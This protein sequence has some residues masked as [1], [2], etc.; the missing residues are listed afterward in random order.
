LWFGE[1]G[2]MVEVATAL[3]AGA[4]GTYAYTDLTGGATAYE[5]QVIAYN[6]SKASTTGPVWGFVTECN[7]EIPYFEGFEANHTN[8]TALSNCWSQEAV[9]GTNAWTANSSETNYNRT[10][11]TGSWNA[12]LRYSNTRWMFQRISVVEATSYTVEVYARQDGATAANASIA[13]SYGATPDA[14]AMTNEIVAQTGII[15]GN[16]Q[17]LTGTFTPA[18]S[19]DIYLGILGTINDTPWYISIDDISVFETPSCLPPSSLVSSNITT[20]TADLG[21]TENGTATTWNIL[22]G[23]EDFD[24]ETEGTSINGV[25]DNPYT[26]EGL[27]SNNTYDWYVQADCGAKEESDWVGP[28]T[29]TTLPGAHP[30][31]LAEDFESGFANFANAAG[32]DVAWVMN[33]DIFHG[34]LQS[35]HNA[36]GANNVNILHE[37]GILDLSGTSAATLEF[38][39]IAKTE[40]GYDKCYVEISIDGGVSYT[41]LPAES[42]LGAGT[43]YGSAGYF[44]EDDYA[45]W[46][47]GTEVP[48]NTWW[49][50]E[51]FSLAAYNTTNVRF[52]FRLTSDGSAQRAGWYIDDILIDEPACPAPTAL[53]S[54]NET[55]TGADLSWTDA[56]GSAWDLYIV[57]AGDPAP[58]GATVPTVD[59]HASTS[60]T[61]AGGVAS[62]NYE[63]YVRSDCGG[64]NTDVSDWSGPGSFSTLCEAVTDFSEDFDG[65]TAPAIPNCWQTI[66]EHPTSTFAHVQTTTGTTPHSAPNHVSMYNTFTASADIE[67]LLISPQVDSDLTERRLR[68]HAKRGGSAESV[69]VG[70]ITDPTDAATFTPLTTIE[71]TA[72]YTEYIYNLDGYAGADEYIAFRHAN[73][74]TTRFV[75]LDNINLEEIPTATLSWYN[76]QWPE[77][78]AIPK[79]ENVTIFAQ[80]WESGVTEPDGPGAGIEAWIGYSDT[81]ATELADFA[82]GWT[83]IAAEYNF[84]A[85]DPGFNNDE[86]MA[87][88]GAAQGL[89]P[90][91]Y[92]YAS[93]FRYLSGPFTYGGFQGGP[94]NGTTNV[95][96]ELT[97]TECNAASIPYFERFDDVV[98]PA[99]PPCMEVEN[100]NEDANE[101][102]TTAT[103]VLSAPNAAYIN[104]NPTIATD[105][106]LYTQGLTLEAGKTYEVGFAYRARSTSYTENLAVWWGDS[107]EAASMTDGPIFVEEGFNNI[108][109]ILGTGIISPDETGV[110]FVGFHG[111]SAPDK[112]GIYLDDI[113]VIEQVANTTWTGAVNNDWH[114]AGNWVDGA[115]PGSSTDVVIPAGLTN[116]PTL[117]FTATINNI[118]I[119]SSAAGTASLLDNNNLTVNGQATIQRYINGG[120][121]HNVSVPLDGGAT[122]AAFMHSYLR[123]F[124]AEG[125]AW[126][127][128]TEP[129]DALADDEGYM[130]WYTGANTTYEFAGDL[131]TGPF[132]TSMQS[133]A[134]GAGADEGKYNLVPNPY[135]S[136]IDWDDL[137]GWTKIHVNDAIYIWNRE[138]DSDP[139]KPN[140]QYAA[141][142]AGISNPEGVLSNH[143]PVGQSFFVEAA[144][145][146]V[147]ELEMDNDVRVHSTQD[148][149]KN[150]EDILDVLRIKATTANGDDHSTIRLLDAASAAFDGSYDARKLNGSSE[151][152]QLYTLTS[153]NHRLSINALPLEETTIVP[154]ALN[155]ANSGEVTLNFTNLQSF[156]SATTIFLEDLLT[157]EM[158]DIREHPA[159]TFNY[160]EGDEPMRFRIHFKGVTSVDDLAAANHH[161]WS[162]D[163]RIY[164]TMPESFG[165]MVRIELFDLLGNRVMDMR[166]SLDNPTIIRSTAKGVVIVRVT[167]ADRVYTQKLFIR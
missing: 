100:V 125:Q 96:G 71:L 118:L 153:D 90:G 154:L 102:L 37:T 117:S 13:V 164:I 111:Y 103:S 12:F 18:S 94:W 23:A 120:G 52:R 85:D 34:G 51:I 73:S 50:K 142:A 11:R 20:N 88:L 99:I 53:L 121:Y 163:D 129:T 2:S 109:Y 108:L 162:H 3:V 75:Y 80:A 131:I 69:Q 123:K 56:S 95:S 31:P 137:V 91:T 48:D 29:F 87:E 84:D 24:P 68:F 58:D 61:W 165:N 30:F 27:T 166:R 113:Y 16:Y 122:A 82:T 159:Y 107:P 161:I 106:W 59:D 152:P 55:T 149:V 136:A 76:L 160:T 128:I 70:T 127:N 43:G 60:Y 1:A 35:A 39:H 72:T 116:Y 144:T 28:N 45:A 133:G 44:D 36:Y 64:D 86:Y 25:T 62:S 145:T 33:T 126:V 130:I 167:E 104:Y 148:F 157:E 101:W 9:A 83:W 22:W 54:D 42:Y 138:D 105:D 47:T 21:W 143:I 112:W 8:N 151:L 141:Y 49:R 32:N 6:S 40:G 17:L 26:L 78:A 147:P 81:D 93:R 41:A 77:T 124:D 134:S 63:W 5:W 155:W 140:G 92:Y 98:A 89:D 65:V 38:W 79:N 7:A 46:G 114:N 15:N 150:A 67:L 132:A 139:S 97:I 135:P 74:G 66:A 146:G 110:Y 19:G 115:L 57:T 156:E 10:P 14:T 158:M 4:T 119:G